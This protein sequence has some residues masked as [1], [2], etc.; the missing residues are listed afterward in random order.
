MKCYEIG[1]IFCYLK[2]KCLSWFE[3]I[4]F[5]RLIDSYWLEILIISQKGANSDDSKGINT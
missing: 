1:N 5:Y 2:N 3:K 4:T